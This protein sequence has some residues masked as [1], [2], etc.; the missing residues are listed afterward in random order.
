LPNLNRGVHSMPF[1]FLKSFM[2]KI[3]LL[4]IL[5]ALAFQG[6]SQDN[7]KIMS[8]ETVNVACKLTTPELQERKKT[9]IAEVKKLVVKRVETTNGI[10]YSF[11]DTESTIDLLTNFI[12]TERLCCAF[13]EFNLVVGQ[14]EGFVFLELSGPEGTKDFIESEIGF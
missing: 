8:K 7:S 10:R 9:V 13:F 12:K 2:K 5:I 1:L 14:T 6:F 3:V 11:N 4:L